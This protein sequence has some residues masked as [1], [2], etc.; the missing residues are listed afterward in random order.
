MVFQ[1]IASS[2]FALHIGSNSIFGLKRFD[3]E[4]VAIYRQ[5]RSVPIFL[6]VTWGFSAFVHSRI[7]QP[8]A[9]QSCR[10]RQK[11]QFWTIAASNPNLYVDFR[12]YQT[13]PTR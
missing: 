11:W 3:Y 2:L 1:S 6:A 10:V 9:A 5:R 8:E 12:C 13:A 4:V 7:P